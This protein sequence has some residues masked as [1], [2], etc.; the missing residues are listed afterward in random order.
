MFGAE[1]DEVKSVSVKEGE[2]VTLN[3]DLTQI[4]EINKIE[5]RFGVKGPIIAECSKNDLWLTETNE[6]FKDRLTLDNQTGSLIIKNSRTEHAGLY[7]VL[8]DHKDDGPSSKKFNVTVFSK[9]F[10]S[11]CYFINEI[12]LN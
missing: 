12:E 10:S 3:P 4:Q 5:W 9:L 6:I 7:K 2:S 8:I 1:T 11:L